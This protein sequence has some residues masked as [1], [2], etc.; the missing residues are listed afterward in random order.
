VAAHYP[1]KKGKRAT[2]FFITCFFNENWGG[3]CTMGGNVIG[4]KRRNR[5]P[6]NR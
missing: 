2:D 3:L 4:G 5:D 1:A 6:S